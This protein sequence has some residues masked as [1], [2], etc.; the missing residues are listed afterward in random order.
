[1]RPVKGPRI[2]VRCDCDAGQ[3]QLAYGERW[4]CDACGRTYDTSQIPAQEY[5]RFASLTRRWRL[6]GYALAVLFALATLLLYLQDEPINLLIG[7][8]ALLVVW[9]TLL[10]P[11]LR[12]RYRRALKASQSA[13]WTLRA[14]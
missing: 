4:S 1:M 6:G 2:T 11:F 5:Q 12:G 7:V 8:P 13:R 10:R 9:F 14:E 3:A